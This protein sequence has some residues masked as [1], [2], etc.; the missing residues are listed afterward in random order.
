MNVVKLRPRAVLEF[1]FELRSEKV[2][3]FADSD[4][5]GEPPSVKSTSGGAVKWSGSTQKSWSS[6]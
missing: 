5:A 2:D 1:P 6:T 3:G 4:R